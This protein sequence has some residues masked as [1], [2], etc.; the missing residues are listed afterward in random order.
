VR[1]RVCRSRLQ[2]PRSAS[3]QKL[4][5]VSIIVANMD[6]LPSSD[7]IRQI[8]EAGVC[9]ERRKHAALA[10]PGNPAIQRSRRRSG[11]YKGAW[12]EQ[13][14]PRYRSGEPAPGTSWAPSYTL[15]NQKRLDERDPVNIAHS[16]LAR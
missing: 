12:D 11:A 15:A 16:A 5:V 14:A 7:L 1:P 10:V 6:H 8:P 4:K 3:E 13:V 2:E 9:A